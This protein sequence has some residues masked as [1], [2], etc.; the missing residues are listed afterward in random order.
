MTP[1]GLL[2]EVQS[3]SLLSR[4]S[5]IKL[6]ST[7]SSF[8]SIFLLINCMPQPNWT[9]QRLVSC[10]EGLLWRLNL[11]KKVLAQNGTNSLAHSGDYHFLPFCAEELER[12]S[13]VFMSWGL[14][15]SDIG[16]ISSVLFVSFVSL[17]L[18]EYQWHEGKCFALFIVVL[19]ESTIVPST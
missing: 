14:A 19:L 18:L 12:R 4:A 13:L 8:N 17:P 6:Q 11:F 7:F 5:Y 3:L 15:T 2:K 1:C 9:H 10:S 16:D